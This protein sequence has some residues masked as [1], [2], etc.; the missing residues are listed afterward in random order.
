MKSKPTR[1]LE[2]NIGEYAYDLGRRTHLKIHIKASTIK[3]KTHELD[4]VKVKNF[5][6]EPKRK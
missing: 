4:Y 5:Y 6:M 1:I 2:D 3:G